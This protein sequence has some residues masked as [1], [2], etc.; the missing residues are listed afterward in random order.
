M[1]F[2]GFRAPEVEYAV[3]DY[4]CSRAVRFSLELICERFAILL[5]PVTIRRHCLHWRPA[6]GTAGA[7][8]LGFGLGHTRTGLC[9]QTSADVNNFLLCRFRARRRALRGHAA[10]DVCERYNANDYDGRY[11]SGSSFL[12][13]KSFLPWRR[14]MQTHCNR[15]PGSAHDLTL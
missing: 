9:S 14:R 13:H 3:E 7:G 1:H 8:P 4:G 15:L 12:C 10:Q 11:H 2:G 5:S 6:S